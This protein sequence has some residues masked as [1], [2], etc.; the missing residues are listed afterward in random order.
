MKPPHGFAVGRLK[1]DTDA[2]TG[3]RRPAIDRLLKTK[4]DIGRN[5]SRCPQS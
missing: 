5:G 4:D 2:V 3:R 1:G